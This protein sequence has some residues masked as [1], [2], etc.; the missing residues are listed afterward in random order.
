M[1]QAEH[2]KH[3]KSTI[4]KF[5]KIKNIHINSRINYSLLT[6]WNTGQQEGKCG[7]NIMD[8]AH[9]HSKKN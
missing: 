8:E 4:L 1:Y 2:Q 9:K 7:H 3:C 5:N 6:Q